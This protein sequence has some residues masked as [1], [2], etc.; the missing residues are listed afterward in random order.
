MEIKL[1]PRFFVILGCLSLGLMLYGSNVLLKKRVEVRVLD[2]KDRG[3]VLATYKLLDSTGKNPEKSQSDPQMVTI[4]YMVKEGDSLQSIADKYHADAQTIVDYPYNNIGDDLQIK[5]GQNLIVP[6]GYIEG[7]PT[8]VRPVIPVGTGQ[9]V[10]PVNGAITQY[11]SWFHPGS[12]DIGIGLGTPVKAADNGK[13]IVVE[14]LKTGY[15]IHVVIDHGV[16]LTSLYG[17]LSQ[18][19]VGRGD[20]VYRGQV[21]GLSGSTGRSTGPHLHFEVERGGNPIDPMTLLSAR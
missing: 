14:Y 8:P 11:N 16:S 21:I 7:Q 19:R 20:G 18:I 17:H 12:I 13:V 9:F 6:N 2:T 1:T 10:W 15:G 4:S 3:K 5:P